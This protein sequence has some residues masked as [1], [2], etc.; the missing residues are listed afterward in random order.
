MND[1]LLEKVNSWADK[2]N[3][4]RPNTLVIAGVSGGADSVCLLHV[5]TML[6]KSRSFSVAA[7]HINHMLRGAESDGDEKFV[8]TICE[9]WGITIRVFREDVGMF[10]YENKYSIEEAGRILRYKRLNQV[11]EETDAQHIAVAHHSG[12]QAETVFLNLLR[13]AG[14]D[15]LSGMPAVSDRIIRPLLMVGKNEIEEYMKRNGLVYRTDSS[16]YDNIYLRN[17]IR[18]DIF[19]AIQKQT[20][21][22]IIPS[23]TRASTHL[24][25]DKDFLDQFTKEKF[26]SVLLYESKKKIVLRRSELIKLHPAISTRIIRMV[27]KKVTGSSKGL[28]SIHVMIALDIASKSG[29]KTAV[30]PKGVRVAAEYDNIDISR[31]AEGEAP[32]TFSISILVPSSIDLPNEE[33][34]IETKLYSKEQYIREFGRIE[35][36]KESSLTQLFDYDRIKKGINIRSRRPGDIFF[37][38]KGSGTKKLKDFLIDIKVPR[39][40]RDTVPLL[41]EDKNIIW[42]IGF[43]TSEK[44]RITQSTKVILCVNIL[45][46]KHHGGENYAV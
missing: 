10:S 46:L 38:Y 5:F 44:Y 4:L 23:L 15:G 9:K 43:R 27:W 11:L 36:E 25:T 19:P 29:N 7:V 37:P 17:A 32:K 22:N 12:D 13:G 21:V 24:K 16:N 2:N 34:R 33:I 42:V 41:A 14:L 6:S 28:E 30:L 8:K 1:E 39:N 20:G 18:N 31:N 35:K 26:G 45:Y 40:K 3:V